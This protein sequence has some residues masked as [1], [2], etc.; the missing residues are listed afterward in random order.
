MA[1]VL[2]DAWMYWGAYQASIL[3]AME[4]KPLA[5]PQLFNVTGAAFDEDDLT[6]YGETT[7]GILYY[8]VWGTPDL[9]DTAGGIPYDNQDTWYTGSG[10]DDDLNDRVERV[11]SDGRARA[12]ARRAY[13]PTGELERPLVTIHNTLDPVVPYWHETDYGVLATPG[14]FVPI[15]VPGYG[16]CEFTEQQVLYAFGMLTSAVGP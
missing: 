10:D 1:D 13:Q 4:A 8:S 11:D 7:L 5:V 12:Y 9:I 14:M 2:D 6:T 15:T 16:H 3:D